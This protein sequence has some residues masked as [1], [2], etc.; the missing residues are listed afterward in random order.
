MHDIFWRPF[1]S[2]RKKPRN[3]TAQ[4][5]NGWCLEVSSCFSS[6]GS[7]ALRVG[8]YSVSGII[9][10]LFLEHLTRRGSD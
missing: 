10:R 8:V 3:V 5:G 4:R 2:K 6:Q 7:G 1:F 9:S